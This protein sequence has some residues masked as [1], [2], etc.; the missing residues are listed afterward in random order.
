MGEIIKKISDQYQTPQKLFN[1]LNREFDFVFDLCA[2]H[3]NV[4]TNKDVF[5]QLGVHYNRGVEKYNCLD[6]EVDNIFRIWFPVI[7]PKI[8]VSKS[9]AFMNPPYSKPGP[10]LEKAWEFSR[11]IKT[12]CLVRDDPSTKWFK[13]IISR[14]LESEKLISTDYPESFASLFYRKD[15]GRQIRIIRLP[16]RIKFEASESMM[17][18]DAKKYPDHKKTSYIEWRTEN[19]V[20]YEL[21]QETKN[22]VRTEDNTIECKCHYPFPVCLIVMDRTKE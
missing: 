21:L 14:Q 7:F 15:E 18:L 12:V 11:H 6:W 8:K 20:Y 17:L 4:K 10:F 1:L 5:T 13:K 2:N 16:Q 3:E 19:N 9:A 22:F